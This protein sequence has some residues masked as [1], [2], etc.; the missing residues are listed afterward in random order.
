MIM[1]GATRATRAT[2]MILHVATIVALVLEQQATV[3]VM[4]TPAATPAVT[5]AATPAVTLVV[6]TILMVTDTKCKI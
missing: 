6:T 5:P 1:T 4:T 3:V 2:T